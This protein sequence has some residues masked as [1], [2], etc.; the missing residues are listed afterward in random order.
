MPF[1]GRGAPDSLWGRHPLAQ[2]S[3]CR[4][5][6]SGSSLAASAPALGGTAQPAS[7]WDATK[8][9]TRWGFLRRVLQ[10]VELYS[11]EGT[12]KTTGCVQQQQIMIMAPLYSDLL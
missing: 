7:V 9:G 8:S 12:G 6:R 11:I 1:G 2:Q 3:Q 4:L 5:R 10:R